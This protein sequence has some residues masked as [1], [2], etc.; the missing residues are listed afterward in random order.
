M[1]SF[2]ISHNCNTTS[3]RVGIF[4]TTHGSIRTPLFMPVGTLATVKGLSSKQLIDIG[5]SMILANTYHL[6]LLPNESIIKQAGGIH[7]FMNW[8][9]PILT[10]SGGYQVFSLAKLRQ[11]NDHGVTFQNPRDGSFIDITPEKS[12]EIQ[13]KLGADVIMAFDHCPSHKLTKNDVE[14]ATLRTHIWLERCVNSHQSN[15]QAL[16]GIIQGGRY[17]DL[18]EESAR[19]V[20]QFDLPGIALGGVSVGESVDEI[21][22][23]I[24]YISPLLPVDKPRY[25]MGI[26]SLQEIALAVANGFDLFDCVMP[27]RLGRHGTALVKG[28]RW[29]LR[30][31]RF[32]DDFSPI[33]KDC[34][35]ETCMNYSRSYLHHLLRCNEILGLTLISIHNISHLLR[36]TTA[37]SRAIQDGCFSEDFTPWENDSIARHTW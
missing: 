29:N 4:N 10:D 8:N 20:S 32:K 21:H 16:F 24:K 14:E 3:A 1:F 28:E 17:K 30:N 25:L 31:S 19:I 11:I 12:I 2:Q 9:R 15:N 18:R 23:V 36:F 37:I 22:N 26:G 6:H 33:D 27:T 7:K 13:M 34:K 35:C 5:A